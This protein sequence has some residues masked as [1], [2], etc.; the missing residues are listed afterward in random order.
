MSFAHIWQDNRENTGIDKKRKNY[1]EPEIEKELEESEEL[2]M[3]EMAEIYISNNEDRRRMKKDKIP[4]M[5]IE[6]L[7]LDLT[8]LKIKM[9]KNNK[10]IM[11]QKNKKM[12]QK[13]EKIE[14]KGGGSA[15]WW[16]QENL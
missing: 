8:K 14:L 12:M 13:T 11:K 2:T 10:K 6:L 1:K 4:E 5:M 9:M 16:N 15:G 7:L 3:E